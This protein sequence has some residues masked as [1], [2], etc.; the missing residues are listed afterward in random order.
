MLPKKI[1]VEEGFLTIKWNPNLIDKVKLANI[2][3]TCPCANC[4]NDRSAE[5]ETY[6]P[7]YDDIQLKVEH[8]E[9][10]GTYAIKIVW[11]DGHDSGIYR[12]SQ[13]KTLAGN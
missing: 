12:F 9:L 2:R 3:K 8:I 11:G 6:I 13:L 5:S 10:V 4:A 1:S 7:I